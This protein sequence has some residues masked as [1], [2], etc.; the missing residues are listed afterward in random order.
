VLYG[1]ENSVRIIQ[2]FFSNVRKSASLCL[3]SSAPYLTLE[4]K[5]YRDILNQIVVKRGI[6][7]RYLTEITKENLPYCKQLM[8]AV[9]LRHLDGIEGNFAVSETDYMATS[10]MQKDKPIPKVIYSNVEEIVKQHQ[11][12][13]ETLW[14]KATPGEQKIKEIEQGTLPIE[15]KVLSHPEEIRERVSKMHEMSNEISICSVT[16]GMRWVYSNFFTEFLQMQNRRSNGQHKGV[17][18]VTTIEKE[19]VDIVRRLGDAGIQIRHVQNLIPVNFAVS[20]RILS[21]TIEEM[22]GSDMPRTLLTST[23]PHYVKHFGLIF[24][25]LWKNGVDAKSRIRQ[26][27]HGTVQAHIEIIHNPEQALDRAWSL[28]AS[29]TEEV[30]LLFSTAN[31]FRRQ[32]QMGGLQVV[33]RALKSGAKVRILLPEDEHVEETIKQLKV[34]APQ[35]EFKSTDK[36][37]ETKI[38]ILVVDRKHCMLFEL[39]DDIVTSSFDAV[40]VTAYS[41]SK[42]IVLSYAAIIQNLWKQAELYEVIRM[43]E[44][45]Q[46]E[47]INI[48][49][50]ELRTPIQPILGMA[51]ILESQFSDGIKEKGE[52]TKDELAML[53]RNAKRLEQ[54]SSD[55][56]EIAR[57]E[58]GKLQLNVREFDLNDVI[59]PMLKDAKKQAG[60]RKIELKY[61]PANILL[62]AD[63][64]RIAEVIWNLLDNAIKFT[65]NGAVVLEVK[66]GDSHVTVTVRDTGNGIDAEVLPKLFTKFVTKSDKGTGLG[67]YI[68]KNII[69][70]HG[71]KIWAENNRNE[72][73]ATFHFTLPLNG[74]MS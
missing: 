59:L 58:T 24:E 28:V 60:S 2:N 17:R 37:L 18:W 39:K 6:K 36:G 65:Q 56:L 20:D 50:H 42:S 33:I 46:K 5:E 13:F 30:L 32:V 69:E 1:I 54:L 21:A 35:A 3:E 68:S 26:I 55:I 15:T 38:T 41:N 52:I 9:D 48:A 16:N 53:I 61:D 73:G 31:A 47:F 66:R 43:Q 72:C 57:I 10:I 67:L 11:Y 22:K 63:K 29:A 12:F 19:D 74:H 14:K 64:D 23:E 45:A 25:K 49:A 4:I 51:D 62:R 70:A 8:N 71:G 7:L 34:A 27:Q 40:G 44:M